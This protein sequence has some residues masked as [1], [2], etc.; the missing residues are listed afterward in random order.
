MNRYLSRDVYYA[1]WDFSQKHRRGKEMKKDGSNVMR[2]LKELHQHNHPLGHSYLMEEIN[3]LTYGIIE[4]KKESLKLSKET[5]LLS[6]A[7][8][9]LEIYDL[10][11]LTDLNLT[12]TRTPTMKIL[13]KPQ[14]LLPKRK[15]INVQ[16]RA[17]KTFY[18]QFA[19]GAKK[20]TSKTGEVKMW[21]L[22]SS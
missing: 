7:E 20:I 8:I 6:R 12:Y 1:L 2:I 5:M 9:N 13:A 4:E 19:Q 18:Y 14:H 15:K 16:K 21:M 22:E 17:V 3:F 10:H 11:L